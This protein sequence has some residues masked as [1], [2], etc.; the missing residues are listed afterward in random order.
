MVINRFQ[1][2][3]T[4]RSSQMELGD[5]SDNKSNT[6][7]SSL[8]S[9]NHNIEKNDD[10]QVNHESDRQKKRIEQRYMEIT[11]QVGEMT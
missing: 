1:T 7:F 4:N 2:L 11:R 9:R 8:D 3:K 10:N 6:S 5:F